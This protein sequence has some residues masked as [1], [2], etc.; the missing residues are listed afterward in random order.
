MSL[1]GQKEGK[2]RAFVPTTSYA[3][4]DSVWRQTCSHRS[5]LFERRAPRRDCGT[6][7]SVTSKVHSCR[8]ALDRTILATFT[9]APAAGNAG[10]PITT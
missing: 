5:Q 2:L 4:E 9:S 6:C 1:A 10:Q 8:Q 3:T 7:D